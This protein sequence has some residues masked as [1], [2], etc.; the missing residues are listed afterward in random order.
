[1]SLITMGFCHRTIITMGLGLSIRIVQEEEVRRRFGVVE[2]LDT[3][4]EVTVTEKPVDIDFEAEE[5]IVE[6]SK[7][8]KD[9]SFEEE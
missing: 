7:T 8:S 1:M 5:V 9:T 2:F 3:T 4:P 6:V